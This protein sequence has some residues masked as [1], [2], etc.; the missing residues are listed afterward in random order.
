MAERTAEHKKLVQEA[1]LEAEQ[2][3]QAQA[4]LPPGEALFKNY[5]SVCHKIN[6]KLVGPPVTEMIQIYGNDFSGFKKW[7]RSP[8][9]KRMDFPAMTGFPQLTDKELEDLGDYIFN[10]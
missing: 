10:Q 8:G 9:R 5:C 2:G 7:V 3:I 1:I 6:E 4:D